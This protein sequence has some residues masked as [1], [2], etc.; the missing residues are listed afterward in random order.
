[1]PVK[2]LI[3][4]ERMKDKQT[5][6]QICN[7][8]ETGKCNETDHYTSESQVTLRHEPQ[9]FICGSQR[10]AQHLAACLQHLLK[11]M[12]SLFDVQ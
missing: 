12:H 2:L 1:M 3:F 5:K 7:N 4:I 8:T 11:I 9:S 6:K 10:S